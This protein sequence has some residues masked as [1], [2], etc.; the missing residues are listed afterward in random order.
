MK[1]RKNI[2]N[3]TL[4][5][6]ISGIML[7]VVGLSAAEPEPDNG[8]FT[9]G[10]DITF[11]YRGQQVTYGTVLSNGLCW[12]DRN[13]GAS[14][15]PTSMTDFQGYGD[16]FQWGRGD[17]GHQK[18]T[19]GT[20]STLSDSDNPG[21]GNFITSNSGANWDWRSPQNNNLWQG[22]NGVNNPCPPGYRLPTEAEWDAERQS[23]SSNDAAGAF[24]SPLK[25]P[26][27]GVRNPSNGSLGL[28]GNISGYWSSSDLFVGSGASRY[29]FLFSNGALMESNSRANGLSVRCI[30]D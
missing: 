20:T 12:M 14:R 22:V 17:D 4:S 1:N 30:K 3:I 19:S 29:L 27:A 11:T 7:F 21:H 26:V 28:V 10:D 2:W 18:R 24:A 23:W 13:L 8:D 6:L 16:L 5:L 9:C 25:L 15:V